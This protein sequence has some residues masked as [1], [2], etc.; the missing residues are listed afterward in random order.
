MTLP[1][2]CPAT[3][4]HRS[5]ALQRS[6]LTPCSAPRPFTRRDWRRAHVTAAAD[7]SNEGSNETSQPD[8]TESQLARLEKAEAEAAALREQLK[9][10]QQ[11]QAERGEQPD[12]KAYKRKGPRIDAGEVLKRET[13]FGSGVRNYMKERGSWVSEGELEELFW[14]STDGPSEGGEAATAAEKTTVQRR[15]L[16]GVGLAAA[17]GA[18]ALVPLDVLT[19]APSQPLFFYLTPLIR[20]QALLE[21]ASSVVQDAQWDDLR[22][23]LTRIQGPPNNIRDNLYS[24]AA[25]LQGGGTRD[26]AKTLASDILE[27]VAQIDFDKYFDAQGR[28]GG[29]GGKRN[30]EF[31]DFSASSVKATQTKLAEF[32]RLFPADDVQAARQQ[33]APP[34]V[35]ED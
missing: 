4:A 31:V 5:G 18:L 24:A 11:I 26:K 9:L 23:I 33:A 29:L 28:G 27:Y 6:L 20:V 10:A 32:L 19:P 1:L 22:F 8:L 35:E 7:D 13:L 12:P 14:R 2:R 25:A 15:L 21:D 34:K 16:L 3:A 30:Q 17:L